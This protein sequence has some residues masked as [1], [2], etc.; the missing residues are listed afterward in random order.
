M[1]DITF[2][3]KITSTEDIDIYDMKDFMD[4]GII[5]DEETVKGYSIRILEREEY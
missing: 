2:E 5:G 1:H 3:V 4:K